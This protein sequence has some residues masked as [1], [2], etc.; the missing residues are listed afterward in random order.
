MGNVSFYRSEKVLWTRPK[1][2][3]MINYSVRRATCHPAVKSESSQCP[4]T[5][6]VLPQGWALRSARKATRF[7]DS[8]R[9]YLEG[10][11]NVGQATG[12]KL[13]P[14]DVARDM[15]YARN[16]GE[17]LFTVSEFLTE[18][19]IQ[20]YFSRR[21]SKLRHSH[22]E[23]PESDQEEDIMAP[24]EE[25]AHENVRAVVLE[26]VGIRH[27]I[28]FD[29]FNLCDMHKAGK[30]GNCSWHAVV[31]TVRVGTD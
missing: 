5:T 16:Q 19:Q 2:Y 28:V 1:Y 26:E 22:L 27:L 18:Q 24:E 13:D 10:K 21:A 30:L 31:I 20:S 14:L 29:N 3:T 9:Q 7:S 23:D 15:R 25:I 17:K 8:Q 11:F 4:V 12:V 6:E